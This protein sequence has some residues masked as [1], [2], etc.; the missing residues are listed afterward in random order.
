MPVLRWVLVVT[1][2]CWCLAQTR[3]ANGEETTVRLGAGSY[4]TA[5]PAGAKE[6]PAEI[7]RT[8][9]VRGPMPTND[10]WSSLAWVPYSQRQFPHPLATQAGPTG[11]HIHYPTIVVQDRVIFGSMPE[12]GGDL[13]LG[14]FQQTEFPEARVDGFSDW[15]VSVR[16][17]AGP[18]QMRVSYGHGSP[19]VYAL[20]EGG[21]PKVTFAKAPVVWAGSER[22]AVLGVAVD[23]KAYAL[24]GPTGSTWSGVGT[25]ILVNHNGGK[26]YFALAL[27]PD[28][29]EAT[30]ARF[31]QS[32]YAHVTDTRVSWNYDAASSRVLTRFDITTK[33]YEGQERG[34]VCALYPHQWRHL[35]RGQLLDGQYASIRGPMKLLAGSGF[36]TSAA[37][38]G[39]LPALP[40]VGRY[41][42][43]IL[44]RYLDEEL[45]EPTAPPKDTYWEGKYLG[46]L[47]TLI[48]IAEQLQHPAAGEWHRRVQDRLEAWFTAS[49]KQGPK[50][51]AAFYYNRNWGTLIGYPASYG[52]DVELNDHHFH[53]GYFI[54]AAAEIA[55]RDPSWG[56]DVKWGPL[57]R[58]LIRD[59]AS[60]DREDRMFPFL[61]NFDPYAGHSWASGHAKFGDGNNQESSSEAMNAWTGIIL[62]GA[63]TGDV[64]L[65]DLGIYLYTTEM[66]AIHEY[67]FDVR[68]ENRPAAYRPTVASMIWGG[69]SER[70]TWFSPK[71][72][73]THGI[74][75][76]PIHGGSLFL[77]LFPD[78]V[79]RDYAGMVAEKG[80]TNWDEWADLIY[81]FQALAD[82]AG[83]LL[84][85][86]ATERTYRGEGG[87][88][89]ANTYHWLQN[90]KT[91]GEVDGTVTA[92]YPLYAVFR[93]RS[94]RTYTAYN[95]SDQP[96]TVR[97][98][99]GQQLAA[100][101]R[102]FAVQQA[103]VAS[104]APRDPG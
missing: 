8:E 43:A 19:Y 25:E 38:P 29:R 47:A 5:L 11:L 28:R 21:E 60:P 98:S 71:T 80:G 78:Y 17:A 61:R 50:S 63:A 4:L 89:R 90:L 103:E 83:A 101:P 1:L 16:W 31:R 45:R 64:A 62:W 49:D 59:I 84:Q 102:Q 30:L 20:F 26:P 95:L 48:P 57:V 100:P 77:G 24:F 22:D 52:T 87:N 7:F 96:L 65:R 70:A 67:W 15:F 35:Q 18:R 93:N 72:E 33:A 39:V 88:S 6:P 37:F 13:T 46:K 76:L 66:T 23:G 34:T 40:D 68:G 51:R 36:S 81:M 44:K 75:W 42:R 41:D 27:L 79:R 82:P 86:T 9:N 99:D 85:F 91:L 92:D 56:T 10:W 12:R 69:K 97:F 32:A 73:P 55:R 54:K 74:N 58:L 14:H 2:V 3:P 104:P 53:Y 94:R